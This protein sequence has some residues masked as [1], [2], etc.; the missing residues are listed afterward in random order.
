MRGKCRKCNTEER[1]K[2]TEQY[3]KDNNVAW[4][5]HKGIVCCPLDFEQK[6]G[7]LLILKAPANSRSIV[8]IFVLLREDA[9]FFHFFQV[10]LMA[11]PVING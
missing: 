5:L 1:R 11:P 8:V 3:H 6:E 10:P 9:N 7:L 2:T 4:I